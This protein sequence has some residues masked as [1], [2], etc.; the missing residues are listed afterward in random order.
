MTTST[1]IKPVALIVDGL[2]RSITQNQAEQLLAMGIIHAT[3]AGPFGLAAGETIKQLDSVLEH[4][5]QYP[6]V[7]VLCTNSEGA[8]EFH[9]CSP[10]CSKAEL[11]E[12]YH[13]DLAKENAEQN[14]YT[15]PMIAFGEKDPAAKQLGEVLAWL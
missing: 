5:I 13:Y 12:G 2:Q 4:G 6:K 1:D 15:G 10:Q 14:G 7:I 11:D 8:P 9:T 3:E